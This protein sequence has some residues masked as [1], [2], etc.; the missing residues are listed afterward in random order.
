MSFFKDL[1]LSYKGIDYPLA[2][3]KVFQVVAAVE[4]HMP[5]MHLAN[6]QAHPRN[7]NLSMAFASALMFAAKAAKLNPPAET[8]DDLAQEIYSE[9]FNSSAEASVIL[10]AVDG[11]FGLLVPP[12][13]IQNK[14]NTLSP[15][16]GGDA[17]SGEKKA[18][19][20]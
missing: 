9:I 13:A 1:V 19:Q 6:Y 5:L 11:L 20:G 17:D 12:Q 2:A 14:L 10:Q 16:P 4:E 8:V 3:N 15:A 18:D 7:A